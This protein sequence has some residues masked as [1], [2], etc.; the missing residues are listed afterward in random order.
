MISYLPEFLRSEWED[1]LHLHSLER[2]GGNLWPLRTG[3]TSRLEVLL[4][5]HVNQGIS[6]SFSPPFSYLQ[7]SFIMF[8]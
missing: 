8:L 2:L 3:Q 5:L 1:V 7:H 6:A 4:V